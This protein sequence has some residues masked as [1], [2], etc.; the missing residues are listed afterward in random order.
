MALW[1][2]KSSPFAPSWNFSNDAF[3]SCRKSS[4]LERSAL[5]ERAWK[6]SS[7][8]LR[9]SST[10]RSFSSAPRRS[11]C[12]EALIAACSAPSAA[13]S[14]RRSDSRPR[15][16][17]SSSRISPARRS[18]SARIASA[19]ERAP[20]PSSNTSAAPKPAPAMNRTTSMLPSRLRDPRYREGPTFLLKGRE[21]LGEKRAPEFALGLLDQRGFEAEQAVGAGVDLAVPGGIRR[22]LPGESRKLPG[23][24]RIEQGVR[25][26]QFPQ[27]RWL[28]VH[29]RGPQP[30]PALQ[31]D[32][33]EEREQRPQPIAVPAGE[34]RE[35]VEADDLPGHR[36]GLEPE[37]PGLLGI[38][39]DPLDGD[40][41]LAHL[42][43]GERAQG[44]GRFAKRL[45]MH[46]QPVR[47]HVF[48]AAQGDFSV[49]RLAPRDEAGVLAGAQPVTD[50]A[51]FAQWHGGRFQRG[52]KAP[53]A[54][55]AVHLPAAGDLFAQLLFR[56]GGE[57]RVA[58]VHAGSPPTRLRP[59]D[60]H[61][62][63]DP[64]VL[65]RGKRL[66]QIGYRRD[67]RRIEHRGPER[68][69]PR[70]RHP[71]VRN[72][73]GRGASR[74]HQLHAP[75]QESRV[76]IDLA[77]AKGWERSRE[78]GALARILEVAIRRIRDQQVGVRDRRRAERIETAEQGPAGGID[79]EKLRPRRAQGES[80]QVRPGASGS[81]HPPRCLAE[82]DAGSRAGIENAPRAL[83]ASVLEREIDDVR[84]EVGRRV[85]HARAAPAAGTE[86]DGAQLFRR[87]AQVPRLVVEYPPPQVPA[88]GARKHPGR[89]RAA[90]PR[91]QRRRSG[92]Q[93]API[94]RARGQRGADG[95]ERERSLGGTQL[96][97]HRLQRDGRQ[98]Y[99]ALT[100]MGMS[101]SN[102]SPENA[103]KTMCWV[104]RF[105]HAPSG[106]ASTV[107][108]SI[109]ALV[110]APDGAMVVEIRILPATLSFGSRFNA[111]SMHAWSWGF[112]SSSFFFTSI[113]F[114]PGAADASSGGGFTGSGGGEGRGATG[115]VGPGE[116]RGASRP[117]SRIA[118]AATPAMTTTAIPTMT[119][120]K[121][122]LR[123]SE[124]APCPR[125]R[126]SAR[127]SSRARETRGSFG[128][129]SCSSSLDAHCA[130][131]RALFASS[132]SAGPSSGE[133]SARPCA[134]G[135][136]PRG[137]VRLGAAKSCTGPRSSTGRLCRGVAVPGAAGFAKGVSRACAIGLIRGDDTGVPRGKG[138]SAKKGAASGT[139]FA[140]IQ[141]VI[142]SRQRYVRGPTF[143]WAVLGASPA[144]LNGPSC[145]LAM[146]ANHPS[147]CCSPA[148]ASPLLAR[149]ARARSPLSMA[150]VLSVSLSGA[151]G[152]PETVATE[153]GVASTGST[154]AGVR[155]AGSAIWMRAPQRLHL[156]TSRLPRSFSSEICRSA[157]QLSQLNCMRGD[158]TTSVSAT[159]A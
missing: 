155:K 72:E 143:P 118:T 19:R 46:A 54:R 82:E 66:S 124:A 75:E 103:G 152:T 116:G 32:A 87:R 8:F 91:S 64:G 97:R 28:H 69:S 76:P 77:A 151:V 146:S 99:P 2:C 115:A 104:V 11:A 158:C 119:Q 148:T 10:R 122:F 130:R 1:R 120:G 133:V 65:G 45:G 140:R 157:W 16:A 86:R 98:T 100:E 83:H 145:L 92:K 50:F 150:R 79:E 6:V 31:G 23:R 63:L 58:A 112:A 149:M 129:D 111:S 5:A 48:A 135:W 35:G 51:N 93:I 61:H 47:K 84:R 43:R 137:G 113:A 24:S 117:V 73:Q 142:P 68:A 3:A 33:V 131:S 9:D 60:E 53:L 159:P 107:L 95:D 59:A 136:L 62:R 67:L 125:E 85:V 7:S 90:R 30:V 144:R 94:E 25:H 49:S 156:T 108:L 26:R 42:P 56:D 81:A 141:S 126:E 154:R 18:R 114:R 110:T 78:E 153:R 38:G 70:V 55:A 17:T 106:L 36:R 96:F 12:N 52:A 138:G 132:A 44:A 39:A 123:L 89:Q 121:G 139:S 71:R 13:I 14:R 80:V 29:V 20:R 88:N 147:P 109:V 128:A 40:A 22:A 134:A 101:T 57:R 105:K 27:S 21:S 127:C 37:R 34:R 74:N 102:G 4:R 15:A 41:R